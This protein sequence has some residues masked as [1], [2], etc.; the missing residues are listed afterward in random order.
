MCGGYFSLLKTAFFNFHT[1]ECWG[2]FEFGIQCQGS[3]EKP[4]YFPNELYT[5]YHI[6][7]RLSIYPCLGRSPEPTSHQ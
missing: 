4:D 1:E 3:V 6:F 7:Y 2:R 5:L